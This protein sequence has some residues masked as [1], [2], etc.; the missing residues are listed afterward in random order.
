MQR[1]FSL[2]GSGTAHLIHAAVF[3][4]VAQ[5]AL[6]FSVLVSLPPECWDSMCAPPRL[7]PLFLSFHAVLTRRWLFTHLCTSVVK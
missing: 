5:A 1:H 4:S 6:E 7:A 3:W 2:G